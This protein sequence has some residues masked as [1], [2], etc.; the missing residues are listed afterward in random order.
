MHITYLYVSYMLKEFRK[1]L[2]FVVHKLD[3]WVISNSVINKIVPI[4]FSSLPG[5]YEKWSRFFISKSHIHGDSFSLSTDAWKLKRKIQNFEMWCYYLIVKHTE[6]NYI[7]IDCFRSNTVLGN[8]KI[9]IQTDN[10][11]NRHKQIEKYFADIVK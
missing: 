10:N 1:L 11:N 9:Y 6:N 8:I 5:K 7:T 2:N 4:I 3:L